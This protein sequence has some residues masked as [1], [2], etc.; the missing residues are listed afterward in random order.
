MAQDPKKR[1]R[2]LAKKAAKRKERSA[3]LR[4]ETVR[5]G[6]ALKERIP[7]TPVHECLSSKRLFE[8]G[9]GTVVISR[10]LPDGDIAA[11]V[12]LL[13]VFCVGVKSC[14][15]DLYT[16]VR[17]EE[18]L[19]K[20]GERELLEPLDAAC[21]KKL[22]ERAL[23]YAH[24]RGLEPPP[25]YGRARLVLADLDGD[26]CPQTFEFGRGGRPC[27]V[28]GPSDTPARRRQILK[29][30]EKSCGPEGFE[31]VEAGRLEG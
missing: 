31:Y 23:L 11:G 17:Y 14:F 28:P 4:A 16:P 25:E 21:G 26:A 10:K 6:S 5:R 29:A 7:G 24:D 1:Q 19:R 12:F 8:A 13:D 15:L 3:E 20:L 2:A 30:L 22:V 18:A 9:L 27:Y